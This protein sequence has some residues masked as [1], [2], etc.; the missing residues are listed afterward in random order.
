MDEASRISMPE[1]ALHLPHMLIPLR[2]TSRDGIIS[3]CFSTRSYYPRPPTTDKPSP[4]RSARLHHAG[5]LHAQ[6]RH[7]RQPRTHYGASPWLVHIASKVARDGGTGQ[8]AASPSDR[9]NTVA[10]RCP[11]MTGL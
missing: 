4:P 2:N 5:K 10:R 1:G 7:I 9:I 3:N 11:A 6:T 8:R